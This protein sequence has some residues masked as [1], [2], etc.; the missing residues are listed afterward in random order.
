MAGA[1]AERP[2]L[3]R[4][5]QGRWG[6]WERCWPGG[7][8]GMPGKKT[9]GSRGRRRRPPGKSCPRG[10]GCRCCSSRRGAPA[11]GKEGGGQKD[12]L[13]CQK[14]REKQAA[15]GQGLAWLLHC[16]S[17]VQDVPVRP[18]SFERQRSQEKS[19]GGRRQWSRRAQ[20][21][22]GWHE[23]YAFKR[24][25]TLPPPRKPTTFPL[26]LGTQPKEGSLALFSAEMRPAFAESNHCPAS[27]GQSA[28]RCQ[29]LCLRQAWQGEGKGG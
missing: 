10:S 9:P 22:H 20:A 3:P 17:C 25:G 29:S 1:V 18:A 13:S 7:R 26:G 8:R 19:P 16:A 21:G 6:G 12:R 28:K 14:S 24:G 11:G 2:R 4:T 23:G 27:R 15:N 5:R